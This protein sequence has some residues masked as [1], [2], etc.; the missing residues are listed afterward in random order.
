MLNKWGVTMRFIIIRDLSQQLKLIDIKGLNYS[1]QQNYL[2]DDDLNIIKGIIIEQSENA[3]ELINTFIAITMNETIKE[4]I[5][6][7]KYGK[8]QKY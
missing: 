5:K 7:L 4:M 1:I 3:I 6:E 8:Q 2:M